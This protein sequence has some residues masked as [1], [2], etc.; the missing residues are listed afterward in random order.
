MLRLGRMSRM[1]PLV[2]VVFVC[3]LGLHGLFTPHAPRLLHASPT[4]VKP[5]RL[6]NKHHL[7]ALDHTLEVSLGLSLNHFVAS[8]P[9]CAPLT[10]TEERFWIE[11]AD[12]PLDIQSVSPGRSRRAALL[13]T[14]SRLGIFEQNG[15]PQSFPELCLRVCV[16]YK[17]RVA[18]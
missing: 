1:L 18:A 15:V 11:V 12:L 7:L 14:K 10:S 2:T 13:D 17:R 6:A 8:H 16:A 5:R 9:C 3:R 4:T